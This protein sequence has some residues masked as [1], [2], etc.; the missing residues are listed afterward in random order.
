[1]SGAS[2]TEELERASDLWQRKYAM[3]ANVL[4]VVNIMFLLVRVAA[5]IIAAVGATTPSTAASIGVA[6]LTALD[7]TATII[8][9][10]NRYEEVSS[11]LRDASVRAKVL[12]LAIRAARHTG[13]GAEEKLVEEQRQEIARLTSVVVR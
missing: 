13:H 12:S 10:Q 1:M 5:S 3:L 7:T 2:L 6:C 8:M 4:A 11:T 9:K